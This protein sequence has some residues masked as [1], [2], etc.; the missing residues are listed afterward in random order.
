M[1]RVQLCVLEV[2]KTWR[3][4]LNG[5]GLGRFPLRSSAIDCAETLAC[6]SRKDGAQVEVLVQEPWGEVVVL[7]SLPWP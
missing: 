1:A 6:E 5:E 3:L 7:E 2:E 4:L